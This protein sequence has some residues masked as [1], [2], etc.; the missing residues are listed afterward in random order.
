MR[1]VQK[2][3]DHGADANATGTWQYTPLHYAQNEAVVKLLLDHGA[4]ANARNDGQNTPLHDAPNEAIAKLLLDRG[5]DV[6]SRDKWQNTPL[7][8]ATNEA[9]VKLLLGHGVDVYS[10]NEDQKTPLHYARSVAIARL[11]INGGVQLEAVDMDGQNAMHCAAQNSELELCLFFVSRGLDPN[12]AENEGETALTI[13]RRD[14][15]LDDED[16]EKKE[17][18]VQLLAALEAYEQRVRDEHWKKNWPLMNTL[19]SSG[20]RPMNA[21]VVA[22]AAQQA[23]SDKSIKLPGIPRKTK[24]QNI[25]YLN[26]A[27]FGREN[28]H[29]FLR[30]IVGFIPRTRFEEGEGGGEE[31]EG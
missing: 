15:G 13:Y 31:D 18:V 23:A 11:L 28:E 3:L 25:A 26:Q 14:Y 30:H 22:L 24:A 10:I 7:H 19:T 2:L 20:L 4:D 21:E 12:I 6:N 29:L 17:A 9:I 8:L 27:V 1:E 5:A 16:E